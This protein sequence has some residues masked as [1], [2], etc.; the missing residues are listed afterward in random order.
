MQQILIFKSI[1]GDRLC[2]RT[3]KRPNIQ[4]ILIPTP[5]FTSISNF[6]VME[7]LNL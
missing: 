3:K 5:Q 4:Q 1:Y 6:N 7:T 2:T